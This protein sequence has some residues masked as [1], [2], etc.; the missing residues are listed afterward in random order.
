[1]V[2]LERQPLRNHEPDLL[3]PE[4]EGCSL[5]RQI[6]LQRPF[7]LEEIRL[8]RFFA[9]NQ[10]AMLTRE[11]CKAENLDQVRL[12]DFPTISLSTSP[13]QTAALFRRHDGVWSRALDSYSLIPEA[14]FLF[15]SMSNVPP[16]RQS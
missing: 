7:P 15:F 11:R 8:L 5:A 16:S 10:P 4:C 2:E 9:P 13:M 1:M 12:P 6:S 14:F 3:R